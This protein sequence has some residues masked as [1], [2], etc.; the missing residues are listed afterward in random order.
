[1]K[2]KAKKKLLKKGLMMKKVQKVIGMIFV[3]VI[4][5]LLGF[6][7][8][9]HIQKANRLKAEKEIQKVEKQV[10][11]AASQAKKVSETKKEDKKRSDSRKPVYLEEA[12]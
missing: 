5:S 3:L 12:K 7:V 10:E 4:C 1:M 8:A 2:K 6:A 9:K 11:E